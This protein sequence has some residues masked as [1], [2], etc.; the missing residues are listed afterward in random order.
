MNEAKAGLQDLF[1]YALVPQSFVAEVEKVGQVAIKNG[2][3]VGKKHKKKK[4]DSQS[5]EEEKQIGSGDCWFLT[6]NKMSDETKMQLSERRSDNAKRGLLMVVLSMV[7][8]SV[9]A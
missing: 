9:G 1:G 7:L 3:K 8:L 5:K 2:G 4:R 6:A